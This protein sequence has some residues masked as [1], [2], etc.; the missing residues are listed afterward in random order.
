M[1]RYERMVREYSE[2]LYWH[3]RRLVVD[4]EDARDILQ[5]TLVAM[6]RNLWQL[7][8]QSRARAWAFR[9]ATNKA[10]RF[11]RRRAEN[12]GITEQL[13]DT[14]EA[15]GYVN[16]DDAAGIRLQKAVMTLPPLQQTVFNLR[17]HDGMEYDEISR[18]TGSSAGS[19]KV[20]YHKAKEKVKEYLT[21]EQ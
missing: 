9:I 21:N 8:D 5:D 11:L 1:D 13:A 18:I 20:S 16:L 15:S 12:V 2:P 6:Y 19:V 3:I 4:H 14:L 10:M 7:H 17:Y